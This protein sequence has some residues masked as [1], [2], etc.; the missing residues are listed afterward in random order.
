MDTSTGF[1]PDVAI[2][3]DG[4]FVV[5][6]SGEGVKAQRFDRLGRRQG[7]EIP[8]SSGFN[9]RVAMDGDGDFVVI[10]LGPDSAA[11]SARLFDR[12]GNPRGD[13][14]QVAINGYWGH[15]VAMDGSG[16]FVAAW[17]DYGGGIGAAR[18]DGLG[19]PIGDSFVVVESGRAAGYFP[20]VAMGA[21]GRIRR[22][23]GILVRAPVR[24]VR[25]ALRPVG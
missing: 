3:H 13:A 4:D 19:A 1:D 22:A 18:F 20:A 16:K 15:A 25:P 5:T 23:R 14:F 24:R 7:V 6:W 12:N 10:W 21:G 9:A 17:S 11:S 8:V 2:D